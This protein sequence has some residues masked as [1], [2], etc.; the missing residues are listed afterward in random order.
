MWCTCGTPRRV[1]LLRCQR[2]KSHNHHHHLLITITI[3]YPVNLVQ[4]VWCVGC[5]EPQMAP[6]WRSVCKMARC[7]SE[8]YQRSRLFTHD[9]NTPVV[10][11]P[12]VEWVTFKIII[13]VIVLIIVIIVYNAMGACWRV[14]VKTPPFTFMTYAMLPRVINQ[15]LGFYAPMNKRCVV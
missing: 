6:H 8:M 12:L 13:I 11:E 10:L 14:G 9:G 3:T 7:K 15:T 1:I 4:T 2:I 5:N